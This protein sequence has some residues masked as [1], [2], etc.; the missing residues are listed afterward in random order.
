MK[1]R[2]PF[3]RR[4]AAPVATPLRDLP[5]D[6]PSLLAQ[7]S[8]FRRVLYFDLANSAIPEPDEELPDAELSESE[9]QQAVA[10]ESL[11]RRRR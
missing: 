7:P 6:G 10:R 2:R 9:W 4:F 5:K 3:R 8:V 1:R 11:R